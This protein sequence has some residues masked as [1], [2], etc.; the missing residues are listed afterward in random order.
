MEE[1]ASMLKRTREEKGMSLK[2]VE[3]ETRVP[4]HY[5]QILEGEGDARLLADVLYLIP[6]L[7]TYS[8][9]LGLD[10]AVTVPHFLTAV[11]KGEGLGAASVARPRRFFSR[12]A[13][14]ALILVGLAALSFL[15]F[16]GEH[17]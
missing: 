1:V 7:R 15:W 4:L 6:F 8:M 11:Q 2:D 14:V 13:V 9:F 12:A 3:A 10:P 17:G 5:L 16:T